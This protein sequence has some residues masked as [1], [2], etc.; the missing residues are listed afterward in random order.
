MVN[1]KLLS[2][3]DLYFADDHKD[4]IKKLKIKQITANNINNKNNII[5]K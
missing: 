3:N 5:I 4:T 1:N 2:I